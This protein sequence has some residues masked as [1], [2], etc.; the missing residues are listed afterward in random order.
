MQKILT[1]E[2]TESAEKCQWLLCFCGRLGDTRAVNRALPLPR[3]HPIPIGLADGAGLRADDADEL[4]LESEEA[5]SGGVA[6]G[7]I[8]F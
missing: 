8:L 1:T 7:V 2:D 6:L 5:M 4:A 3:L